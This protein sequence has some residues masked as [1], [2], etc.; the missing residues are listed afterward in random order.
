MRPLK[1]LTGLPRRLRVLERQIEAMATD[2]RKLGK[3]PSVPHL[4]RKIAAEDA[5]RYVWENFS[6]YKIYTHR[7][8]TLKF[9]VE[10]AGADGLFL[11]FGVHT[12]Q[13]IR[14]SAKLRPEIRFWGF[15]SFEGLPEDWGGSG[16]VKGDFD[17]GGKLPKVPRNVTLV[18]GWFDETV[19][20]WKTEHDG[21]ISYCHVDCDLYS[22]TVTIFRE[23]EDRFVDGTILLFDEYFG[24]AGW[25]EGEHKAFLE[26]IERTGFTYEPLAISHMALVVRLRKA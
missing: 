2:V 18:K 17:L 19:P 11:E 22:S 8:E 5:A 23:L 9:A 21:P 14:L 3:P 7:R 15:D 24:Y 13:T 10:R 4:V 1:F 16:K 26:M 12:G 20:T 25:R 6:G